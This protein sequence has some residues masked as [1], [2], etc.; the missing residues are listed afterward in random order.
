M[1]MLNT[2]ILLACSKWLSVM[3]EVISENTEIFQMGHA[4]KYAFHPGGTN[5]IF[6][7]GV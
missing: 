2:K 7:T 4:M 1:T 3:T 5:N 6:R